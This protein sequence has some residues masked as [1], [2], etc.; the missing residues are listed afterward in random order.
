MSNL[1]HDTTPPPPD[2]APTQPTA[3]H[4]ALSAISEEEASGAIVDLFSNLSPE[5]F[6]KLRPELL[7]LPRPTRWNLVTMLLDDADRGNIV[8]MIKAF[9][10]GNADKM[11]EQGLNTVDYY[12]ESLQR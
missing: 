5:D 12:L 2:A 10:A 4:S 9:K 7:K 3:L 11:N 6:Q 8:G 1:P